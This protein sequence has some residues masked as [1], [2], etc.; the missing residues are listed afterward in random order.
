LRR[1]EADGRGGLHRV[2]VDELA[3]RDARDAVHLEAERVV[4]RLPV[5]LAQRDALEVGDDRDCELEVLDHA[6]E[7]GN[8]RVARQALDARAQRVPVAGDLLLE[9]ERLERVV[10]RL[11]PDLHLRLPRRHGAPELEVGE[12]RAHHDSS[13]L[14]SEC[15]S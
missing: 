7:L 12:Q 10:R 2:L 8:G 14:V 1:D 11:H 3:E 15:Q 4:D 9:L 13:F 6:L 5:A